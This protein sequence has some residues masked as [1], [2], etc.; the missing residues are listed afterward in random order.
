[1]IPDKLNFWSD[2]YRDYLCPTPVIRALDPVKKYQPV[3]TNLS[4]SDMDAEKGAE[5]GW[6]TGQGSLDLSDSTTADEEKRIEFERFEDEDLDGVEESWEDAEEYLDIE[7]VEDEALFDDGE[8]IWKL[9]EDEDLFESAEGEYFGETDEEGEEV[10]TGPRST[11]RS[12]SRDHP[13]V[14]MTTGRGEIEDKPDSSHS[15][16]KHLSSLTSNVEMDLQFP[17]PVARRRNPGPR[18][19]G[20]P[21]APLGS[22]PTNTPTMSEEA[23]QLREFLNRQTKLLPSRSIAQPTDFSLC[24]PEMSTSLLS[25][26]P[27]IHPNLATDKPHQKSNLHTPKSATKHP[28]GI[29]HRSNT[30][31]KRTLYPPSTAPSN[32]EVFL[33][34][35]VL[36]IRTC[37]SRSISPVPRPR[38][39]ASRRPGTL[40]RTSLPRSK[41]SNYPINTFTQLRVYLA[42]M[43]NPPSPLSSPR[44]SHARLPS[45]DGVAMQRENAPSPPPSPRLSH[46]GLPALG[47]V[48]MQR[49]SSSPLEE[50]YRDDD[51]NFFRET[52]ESTD[53]SCPNAPHTS[54]MRKI[55]F[56]PA[57]PKRRLGPSHIQIE[58]EKVFEKRPER[59]YFEI[60]YLHIAV[61]CLDH[62]E[63]YSGYKSRQAR[64]RR[65]R[66]ASRL[67]TDKWNRIAERST[68]G[69][70]WR[71]YKRSPLC[72][73]FGR[74]PCDVGLGRRKGD[75]GR[76]LWHSRG[77][78][79]DDEDSRLEA[80]G[81]R[82]GLGCEYDDER[83]EL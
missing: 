14:Q 1:V 31:K 8:Q 56:P 38:I 61:I 45:S 30:R 40:T 5:I 53:R 20:T 55:P 15:T 63:L 43:S 25:S 18:T 50:R 34:A 79:A 75:W 71:V 65:P 33:P 13:R 22:L 76:W 54:F 21:I 80:W 74:F 16:H 69:R 7:R 37:S 57:L 83:D 42:R 23:L 9:A 12:N 68:G 66:A 28:F 48:A 2:T 70:R 46:A 82:E 24:P 51:E 52:D 41:V 3:N 62:P 29:R 81:L 36:P 72:I 39:S 67:L 60:P 35:N 44:P 64:R 32:D 4:Y 73:E 17:P 59:G 49:E 78:P 19:P 11:S 27:I 47:G 58:Q 10:W 26:V 6:S 77:Y